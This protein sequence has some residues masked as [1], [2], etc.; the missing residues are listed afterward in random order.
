M[1]AAAERGQALVPFVAIGGVK[2]DKLQAGTICGGGGIKPHYLLFMCREKGLGVGKGEDA[3]FTPEF[4]CWGEI[5]AHG[6]MAPMERDVERDGNLPRSRSPLLSVVHMGPRCAL[7][8]R[9]TISVL[10]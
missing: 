1:D 5:I 4:S 6:A 2:V 7:S 10:T 8:I 3:Q 9:S